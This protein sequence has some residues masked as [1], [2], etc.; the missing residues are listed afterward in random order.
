MMYWT[1]QFPY[2]ASALIAAG[3]CNQPLGAVTFLVNF[4][5]TIRP[6]QHIYSPYFYSARVAPNDRIPAPA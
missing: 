6:S 1:P 5:N 4:T 2:S 3:K